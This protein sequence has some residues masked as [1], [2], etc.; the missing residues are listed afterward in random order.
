MCGLFSYP[1]ALSTTTGSSSAIP[2][3]VGTY[4]HV[5][6]TRQGSVYRLFVDGIQ[7]ITATN[8]YLRPSAAITVY[9][10][11]SRRSFI[12]ALCGEIDDLRITKG[13]ARYPTSFTPP[14]QPNCDSVVPGNIVAIPGTSPLTGMSVVVQQQSIGDQNG[15]VALSGVSATVNAGGLFWIPSHR[16]KQLR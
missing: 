2:C 10:G 6:L 3:S 9:V 1:T 15:A 8:A 14:A 12:D 13:I 5:A 4:Q 11:N 16:V 7:A